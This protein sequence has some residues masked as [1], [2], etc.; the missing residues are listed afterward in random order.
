MKKEAKP[1]QLL[2][3]LVIDYLRWTQFTPMILMW[4][5][6][7]GMLFILFFVSHEHAVWST[8][9]GL[10]EWIASLPWNGPRFLAFMESRPRTV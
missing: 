10:T 6:V 9:G 2:L 1:I 8:V 3:S 5:I 7:L 4:A